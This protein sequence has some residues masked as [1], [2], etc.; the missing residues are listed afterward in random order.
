MTLKDK[1][2]FITGGTSGIGL[3]TAIEAAKQGASVAIADLKEEEGKKAIE[4]LSKING[5]NYV[6]IRCDVSKA[7]DCKN[8]IDIAVKHFGKLDAACNNAG[9]GGAAA[10]TGDYTEEDWHKL[11]GVNLHGVFYCM[12]YELQQ[13]M[14][15]QH[16]SIINMSSILGHVGFATA[17]AYTAAKHGLIGLTQTAAME[18]GTAG[19]RVNAVC[20][21]FIETP[22]LKDAG[23]LDNQEMLNMIKSL[24]PMKRLGKPE[25]IAQ[26]VCWLASDAASFVTG[27][28]LLVDGGY[29]AQ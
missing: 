6:F 23:L 11:M 27:T 28:S 22:M 1:V 5:G 14:K 17:C 7:E 18:Y 20:P 10:L 2:I 3:A 15:Q 21:G 26:A 25:E 16:G 19:I 8:A 24:H 13:M 9:I 4:T 29:T 12:K